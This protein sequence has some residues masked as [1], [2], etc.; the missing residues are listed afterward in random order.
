[1]SAVKSVPPNQPSA[2]KSWGEAAKAYLDSRVIVM[3]FLGFSAG[4]P[5]LLIFSSLSLWLR[6]AGI[7]RSVVTMFSWAALGYSFKFIWAPLID[8]LPVP[9]LTKWL[10]RRRSWMVVSQLL[11][12]L[13]IFLMATVN[14]VSEDV[15]IYMAGAAVLLGF[16]SATQDIVIDA[17]RIELAPPSMQSILSSIYVSGYRIGMIVAGAGALYLAD[18]FGS[19]EAF[20]SY[21][22]WRN[23]YYIMAGVMTLGILTTFASY[24]PTAEILQSNKQHRNLKV[25]LI[26]SALLLIPGLLFGVVYLLNMLIN[27]A[28]D[29]P[30]ALIPQVALPS[31]KFYF[32]ALVACAPLLLLYFIINQPKIINQ[33]PLVAE[34]RED[35]VRLVLLFVFAVVA[36]IAAYVLTGQL[37]PAFDGV[38]VSFVSETLHLLMSLAV[39]LVAGFALVQAGLVNKQIAMATW[40]E[41][42]VDFFRRY[43]M[44]AL[45]LLALIGLYR[46]S[47]IVAGV[48][49]NVFYQDMGFSKTDIANAVKLVGVIMAIAGGFLGGLLAQR[50]R[51]MHAMMIG[52]ILA[53]ATNLLFVVLTY[54]PGSLPIM[55]VAVIFDNLAAGLASAV[56]IAFLSALTSIRFTAVQYAIFSSL[57][58][59]IPKVMGGYSG[60]IVDSMGYPFFFI[61]T[62]AIGIPILALIYFVDKHIV[63][64]DNDDIYDNDDDNP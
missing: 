60:S 27:L 1:M 29:T 9:F 40:I 23:T 59:L 16:S 46:I 63:I 12:V 48:I 3:L 34:T 31:I 4:I 42:I 10:G 61:F 36:F 20:Y 39:A 38:F 24:E 18:Y 14:P 64:G 45:L 62:F 56:F 51:I 50:F 55:Y 2:K 15:L 28:L 30:V 22:A 5:I 54:N 44:K 17:Y 43:G 47:D 25:F 6:E 35:Y 52:A 11:I 21:E 7:D 19:T 32:L 13:A 58:T 8:A 37:L 26:Y 49:S 53:C 41:P 33:A 57:M